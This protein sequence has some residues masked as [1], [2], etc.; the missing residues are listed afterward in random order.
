MSSGGVAMPAPSYL[1]DLRSR[2][3]AALQVQRMWSAGRLEPITVHFG[4]GFLGLGFGL[5]TDVAYSARIQDLPTL[6]DGT[7]GAAALYNASTTEAAKRLVPG[8]L[9]THVNDADMSNLAYVDTL[10]RVQAVGRPVKLRFA[11]PKLR[12]A[13]SEVDMSHS[14]SNAVTLRAF[15]AVQQGHFLVLLEL[16]PAVDVLSRHPSDAR[17]LLHVAAR[18]KNDAVVSWLLEQPHGADLACTRNAQGRLPLHDAMSGG[19]LSICDR[20]YATHPEAL[21]VG[22]DRGVSCVHLAAGNG[23]VHLF[24]WLLRHGAPLHSTS[25]DGKTALHYACAQGHL[26]VVIFLLKHGG[27]VSAVD[28]HQ[29]NCLHYTALHGHLDL[30]QWLVFQTP[31]PLTQ[32]NA[33]RLLPSDM[34][35][36]GNDE[37]KEFLELVSAEPLPPRGFHAADAQA[38]LVR[39]AWS[40]D[41]VPL[42]FRYPLRPY[43]AQANCGRCT[44]VATL[45]LEYGR[46]YIGGWEPYPVRLDATAT[47]CVVPELQ[48]NTEYSFRLRVWNENGSS[49]F[50]KTTARTLPATS[51]SS[52]VVR[53]VGA[54]ARRL[55][56]THASHRFYMTLCVSPG[57][58][59]RSDLGRLQPAFGHDVDAYRHPQWS[60]S[61]PVVVSEPTELRVAVYGVADDGPYL[62]GRATTTVQREM[63]R[64]V[65]L[66]LDNADANE[67]AVAL[68]FD[69]TDDAGD[70]TD[71]YGFVVPS[72]HMRAYRYASALANCTEIYRQTA[73][74][75]ACPTTADADGHMAWHDI[76]VVDDHAALEALAWAG[77]PRD[78]RRHVYFIGGRAATMQAAAGAGYYTQLVAMD[79][80][81]IRDYYLIASDVQ[82]TFADQPMMQSVRPRLERLLLA[83]VAHAPSLGYCQSMNYLG[84]RLL[85][86]YANE[87][88]DDDERAFWVFASLCLE[89]FP[90]YYNAGLD[91]LHTDGAVLERLLRSRLPRL[92]AHCRSLKTPMPLLA[93]QWFLPLFCQTLPTETTYRLLDV[94][95]LQR[96][97]AVVFALV[98]AHL[99]LAAPRLLATHDYMDFTAEVRHVEAGL[100]DVDP[101]LEMAA[102]EHFSL[103]DDATLLRASEG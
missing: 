22:D 90:T 62:V 74:A 69:T 85:T 21:N 8:L 92:S 102:K 73:W 40:V 33:K 61:L 14:T 98:L 51:T 101:L 38:T 43:R 80:A 3:D 70:A 93:A 30:A 24:P 42:E 71:H 25:V 58:C 35:P 76:S 57:H 103:G 75:R 72:S 32:R 11:A 88:D 82:R 36:A 37:L 86:L 68:L 7:A 5:S 81:T 99:R 34:V 52:A 26:E 59:V 28:I 29:C 18:Y 16:W 94:I 47:S 84:A 10:E 64:S 4:P 100:Y 96:S 15:E 17:S 27:S 20:L 54:E 23:H 19:V 49:A 79:K 31:I 39:L 1:Q 78:L 91:G 66:R 67:G 65:W 44:E 50:V 2:T 95:V 77:V 53:L 83:F 45:E 46:A 12:A 9:L 55:P 60:L 48:P 56:R 87:Q 41:A 89:K 63:P 97:T 13:T 6:P